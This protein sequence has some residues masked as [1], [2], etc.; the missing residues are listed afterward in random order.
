MERRRER[1]IQ[2]RRTHILEAARNLIARRGV[3]G[4]SLDHIAQAADYTRRTIYSYFRSRDD[5]LL[6][7]YA[8]DLANRRKEQ[9]LAMESAATGLDKLIAWGRSF[10]TYSKEHPHDNRVQAYWD[11]RGVDR[12]AISPEL[13]KVFK[14]INE[15]VAVGL[16]Q[17]FDLGIRDGSLRP[18]LEADLCL[19]Q[20]IYSLRAV[21][22]R[23]LTPSYSFSSVD[24]DAL[25]E[26]ALGVLRIGLAGPVP[27]KGGSR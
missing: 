3:E 17:A 22:N 12:H 5:V 24:P 19:S 9:Q 20:L 14:K 15:S 26:H 7:I 21:I 6:K 18:G 13:F 2:A 1:E 27:D 16:R 23:A 4:T 11:F 8:E 25:V 10:F